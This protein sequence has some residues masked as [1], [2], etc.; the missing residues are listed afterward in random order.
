MQEVL[1]ID[2]IKARYPDKWVLV[3][4]PEL[5]NPDLL[6]AIINKLVRGVVLFVS[7]DRRELGYKGREARQGF[8]SVT[9]IYTGE[10]PKNR[11]WLL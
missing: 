3:G 10:M 8:E 4:N 9:C 7:A 11:K 6:D 2:E 5:S 1:T